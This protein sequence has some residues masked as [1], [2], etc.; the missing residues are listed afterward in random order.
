MAN[1]DKR[2]MIFPIKRL[3]DL[4]FEV[5]ATQGTAEVL[6][7]NG[8]DA[9]VVRKH[10]EGDGPGGEPTTVQL[11]AAGEIDLI[12][13]TPHGTGGG[14]AVRDRRLRD[15]HR[16][17]AGQRPV[18]HH[19]AGARRRRAGHR[20]DAGR[21]DRGPVAAGLGG[22]LTAYD[23]LFRHALSRVDPE[24]AHHVGFRAVRAGP[25]GAGA[26]AAAREPR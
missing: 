13:N 15:P 23:L 2:T 21:R 20:G 10:Y 19:R 7:R 18:H 14:G 16:R 1:R 22:P 9:R 6:R 11:I 3:A 25:A 17:G 12:V 4:G 5:L 26:A 24:R 8:I